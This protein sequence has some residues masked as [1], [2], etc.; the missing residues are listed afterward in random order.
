MTIPCAALCLPEC[1]PPARSTDTRYWLSFSKR[2]AFLLFFFEKKNQKTFARI[3]GYWRRA[4]LAGLAI[5]L[6]QGA[7]GCRARGEAVKCRCE[8]LA[9]AAGK[10]ANRP[11]RG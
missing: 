4:R 3:E 2:R 1:S 9:T 11:A 10:N 7:Q 5:H 8:S 6:N